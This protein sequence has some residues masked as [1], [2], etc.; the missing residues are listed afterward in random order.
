[1]PLLTKDMIQG[2]TLCN[3]NYQLGM[4]STSDTV[5][6]DT[7]LAGRGSFGLIDLCLLARE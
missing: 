4:N 2:I 6:P 1:M 5:Y 7:Y 3:V